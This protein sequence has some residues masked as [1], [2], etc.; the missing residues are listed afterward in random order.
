MIV[1]IDP[2]L[3]GGI[4]GIDEDA[5][6]I[7]FVNRMPLVES[8][9]DL[10]AYIDI[11]KAVRTR[12]LLENKRSVLFIERAQS[13]PKQG[14]ASAFN[15]GRHTG[16]LEGIARCLDFEVIRVLASVWTRELHD[17]GNDLGTKE[18]SIE[19]AKHIFKGVEFRW[20]G[21][22]KQQF[23]DGM[24]EAALI[25]EYGRRCRKPAAISQ[26]L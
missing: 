3:K 13:M 16:H 22:R 14:I 1:G 4:A 6:I 9:L 23:H 2:G 5:P 12:N 24:V 20:P 11:M 25:A 8:E 26:T 19:T 18:R 17:K 7:R 15:Y 10:S 21:Q